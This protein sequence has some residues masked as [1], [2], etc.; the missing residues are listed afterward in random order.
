MR[1]LSEGSGGSQWPGDVTPGVS[2]T[3]VLPPG[4]AVTVPTRRNAPRVS[5]L[6]QSSIQGSLPH[7][8]LLDRRLTLA[9]ASSPAHA[10][11]SPFRAGVTHGPLL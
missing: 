8:F 3:R 1:V 6:H 2:H 11:Q 5:A 4:L 7:R 10:P 9:R